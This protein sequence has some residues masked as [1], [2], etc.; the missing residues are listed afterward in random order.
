MLG[1]HI[2]GSL[3]VCNKNVLVADIDSKLVLES[4]VNVNA[5][6]DVEE[7]SL[8]APVGVEGNGNALS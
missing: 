6:V 1:Y 4:L 3:D 7:A 5:G 8:V 2:V